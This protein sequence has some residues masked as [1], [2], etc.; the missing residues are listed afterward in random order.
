MHEFELFLHEAVAAGTVLLYATLGEILAER[1]GVI[2]LG[3]EGIMLLGAVSAF[4]VSIATGSVPLSVLVAFALGC[5]IGII[6]GVACIS[7]RGNQI[8]SGLALAMFCAGLSSIIG[9][10]YVGIPPKVVLAP[11]KIPLLSKIP[12]IGYSFFNQNPL[13]YVAYVTSVLLW[14]LLFKTKVGIA[15]RACGDN[16]S[17]AEA[18]GINVHLYRYF[19]T[20]LGAGLA[21]V[22]GAYLTLAYTPF[23]VE[24]ITAG[25]GWIALALV[26]LSTWNPIRALLACYFFG[27]CEISQYWLQTIGLNPYLLGTIPYIATILLITVI[28]VEKLRKI[29]GAPSALGKP[30]PED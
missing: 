21:A 12:I 30:Y 6:H 17:A 27:F 2:N 13:V 4:A 10:N 22:G 29:I 19:C 8:V 5:L 9:K 15:I 18:M 25:R 11:I 20:V 24:G 1:S 14:L 7:L 23:W 16:P 26:I 3:I 28:H